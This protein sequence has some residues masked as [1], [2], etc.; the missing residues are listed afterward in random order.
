MNRYLTAWVKDSKSAFVRKT[1]IGEYMDTE[2]RE[3]VVH[4]ITI[5]GGV[6]Y[7]WLVTYGLNSWNMAIGEVG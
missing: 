1:T 6:I 2:S 7:A 5:Y 3:P 4:H